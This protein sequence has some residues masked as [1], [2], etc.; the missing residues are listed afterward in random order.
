[1]KK[2][3]IKRGRKEITAMEKWRIMREI[4]E[5]ENNPVMTPLSRQTE[6][7]MVKHHYFNR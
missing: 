3:R 4:L 2:R 5:K 7:N 1:V 6:Q